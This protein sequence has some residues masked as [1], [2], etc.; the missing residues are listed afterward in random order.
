MPGKPPNARAKQSQ[1][2]GVRYEQDRAKRPT[3]ALYNTARWQR[4]RRDQLSREPLC[5]MCKRDGI[6]RAATVCDHAEP[7]RGDVEAFWRGP[8]RSLCAPHHDGEKQRSE[9]KGRGMSK[10]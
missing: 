5:W 2:A 6:I 1:A 10:P 3:R 8:F 7:H 9:A 4:I